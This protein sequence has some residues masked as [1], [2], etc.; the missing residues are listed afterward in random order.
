MEGGRLFKFLAHLMA[1]DLPGAPW[2]GSVF[3]AVRE[4]NNQIRETLG[5]KFL[6][7][8]R[9]IRTDP[10]YAGYT[11]WI[12]EP[13]K[14]WYKAWSIPDRLAA[15]IQANEAVLDQET[16]QK[17][18]QILAR[19]R[20]VAWIIPTEIKKTLDGFDI[21][22]DDHGLSKAS[23]RVMAAWKQWTLISPF[24]VIKY[25]LNNMSGDLD[26]AFAYRPKIISHYLPAVIRDLYKEIKGKQMPQAL[27]EELDLAYS[28]EVLGSG[29]SVQEVQDVAGQLAFKKHMEALTGE[30][31]TWIAR[32][33]R[34]FK[35]FTQYREN[36][37]R[38][39]A[40]RFFREELRDGKTVYGA[41]NKAEIDG[42][43][44]I[45]R[46]AAKLAR[47]LLGDYGNV[48]HAGQWIRRHLLPFYAWME[49]NA[50]R[51]VRMMRNVRHEGQGT[52]RAAR[53]VGVLATR[54]AWKTSKLA[55][56]MMGF[57]AL[58]SLWNAAFFPDEEEELGEQQRRQLHLI[59]GRRADGFIVTLRVQGAFSD[60]L[61]W[62]GMED[63][64]KDVMDLWYGKTSITD[65][66]KDSALATPK[67]II[68]A[69]GP[70][71]KM[72]GELLLERSYH[73]DPFNPRPIR[74]RLEYVS[75][76]FSLG[77]VYNWA[78][79]A[80]DW[81]VPSGMPMQKPRR[82]G[83]I[84]GRLMNDLMALALYTADPGE[85]AYFDSTKLVRDYRSKTL[86]LDNPDKANALYYYKQSLRM[87]DLK[88]AEK[89]LRYYLSFPGDTE[90][91]LTQ[92][93]KRAHPLGMLSRKD[94]QKFL[95]SLS[96]DARRR[97]ETG[98][99]WYERVY[100]G[101][102]HEE[103]KR[104]ARQPA[105]EEPI[106]DEPAGTTLRDVFNQLR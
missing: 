83:T 31:P 40:F 51:Y 60:A 43:E 84:G 52:G 95:D 105:E 16:F 7:P 100:R 8:A 65:I 55:M 34:S 62:F 87:G 89:Y 3:K 42:I 59:L 66:A 76:T 91:G 97:V 48:T 15:Q 54:A 58:V 72:P 50:P 33:W 88:S 92:S 22:H 67:K 14:T 99:E 13:G 79:G 104:R 35:G 70:Q 10:Q 11:E 36:L 75:R 25:N 21:V 20:D 38:L 32:T 63:F 81:A 12:P 18:R 44:D 37:L 98:I 86:G 6:T 93:I 39:A 80:V 106:E 57:F 102:A 90:R 27:R 56:K 49:V 30:E 29:W 85:M 74:D 71:W 45:D 4:R 103:A 17:A 19:G 94:R 69:L 96:P 53:T 78:A 9:I 46:K 73:P 41:S 64:S 24:R 28:L 23:A 101:E 61:S 47:E 82:G 26:V 77:E 1:N 2:A 5:D 68:G